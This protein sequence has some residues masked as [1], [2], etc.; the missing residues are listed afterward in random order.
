MTLKLCRLA[1]ASVSLS[2]AA[3][4]ADPVAVNRVRFF[5]APERG[6][7][8]VGGKITG[9]NL[10]QTEGFTVLAEIKAAPKRGEWGELKFENAAPFR[11]VRYEAPAGSRGNIAELEFYAGDV[12]L[13]GCLLYTSDA[14]DE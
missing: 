2:A 1:L 5:P 4:A 14:A 3:F 10:S 7:A 6:Q 9:S 13:K 11:W 12:K 8:M